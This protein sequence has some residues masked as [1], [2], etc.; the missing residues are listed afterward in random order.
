MT[1]NF[2]AANAE[3][4]RSA[5]QRDTRL[6][7]AALDKARRGELRLHHETAAVLKRRVAMPGASWA[8]IAASLDMS[9]DAAFSRFRRACFPDGKRPR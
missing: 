3:R 2:E 1:G 4:Q 7:R 9:K 6:A 5:A 8:D